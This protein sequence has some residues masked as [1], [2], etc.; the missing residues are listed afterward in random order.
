MNII[1][2]IIIAISTYTSIPMPQI[3]W[4]EER[5]RYALCFFPLTGWIISVALVLWHML[6]VSIGAGALLFACGGVAVPLL[7]TGGIH[8]DGYCDTVDALAS[9][10][11]RERKLEIMKD[12]NA[13]AF[14]V[15]YCGVYLLINLGLMSE[16]YQ[17]FAY[18]AACFGYG[19]SRSLSAIAALTFKGARRKGMLESFRGGK[20]TLALIPALLGVVSALA[21]LHFD[22]ASGI[23]AIAVALF[24]LL[25]YRHIAYK[26]FEGVTGDT[27]GFFLQLCELLIL[28][29][30]FF[31]GSLKISD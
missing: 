13:G 15:I 11:N 12:P 27:S 4:T 1:Y 23:A 10:Q 26:H 29:A 31:A 16:L 25:L 6:C 20:H 17:S 22:M 14:A 7:I 18:V 5:T 28:A 30:I 21:M 3:E 24:W 9:R 8:M 2:S 19:L